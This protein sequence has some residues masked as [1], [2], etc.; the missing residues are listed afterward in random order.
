[1]NVHMAIRAEDIQA[2]DIIRL[3][4]RHQ[5]YLVEYLGE[6][7]GSCMMIKVNGY[8][9]L[10]PLDSASYVALLHRARPEGEG[11]GLLKTVIAE[12]ERTYGDMS[13]AGR[14]G[15]GYS[16]EE[17][18]AAIARLLPLMQ[19]YLLGKSFQEEVKK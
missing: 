15:D 17:A 16:V 7:A 14:S 6:R 11:G 3:T 12:V 4:A 5:P 9:V 18:D 2:G 19:D 10:L 8:S 1:M 13:E